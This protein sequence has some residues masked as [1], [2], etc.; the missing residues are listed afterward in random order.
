MV[1]FFFL[2]AK[3]LLVS[4][5]DMLSSASRLAPT[6]D[7]VDEFEQIVKRIESSPMPKIPSTLV[8]P[9]GP[10]TNSVPKL[11]EGPLGMTGGVSVPNHVAALPV[12][13]ASHHDHR[14]TKPSSAAAHVLVH[15]QAKCLPGKRVVVE[16]YILCTWHFLTG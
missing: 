5:R 12:P 8:H 14:S 13:P 16:G 4:E 15:W 1:L 6:S 7:A 10:V 2:A 3:I 9:T 11:F